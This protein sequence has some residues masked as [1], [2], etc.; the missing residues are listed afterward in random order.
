MRVFCCDKQ[1][2]MREFLI[3]NHEKEEEADSIISC[4]I[5]NHLG[6]L[7]ANGE[8]VVE[9]EFDG[10]N[11]MILY[12]DD[13][14]HQFSRSDNIQTDVFD[15]S[16]SILQSVGSIDMKFNI[17]ETEARLSG[18]VDTT[19]INRLEVRE[20]P[21]QML[22]TNSSQKNVKSSKGYPKS[23]VL[24]KKPRMSPPSNWLCLTLLPGAFQVHNLTTFLSGINVERCYM[25]NNASE[26][27]SFDVF[28]EFDKMT[29]CEAA[30]YRHQEKVFDPLFGSIVMEFSFVSTED[31][32]WIPRV[33]PR[34]S[35][36]SLE[37]CW[38][39]F[40]QHL[41][42]IDI[43]EFL[44]KFKSYVVPNL[45]TL[46][47]KTPCDVHYPLQEWSSS[48]FLGFSAD[49]IEVLRDEY[50][51]WESV[52]SR[53]A[54]SSMNKEGFYQAVSIIHRYLLHKYLAYLHESPSSQSAS[55]SSAEYEYLERLYRCSSACLQ[56]KFDA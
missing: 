24:P 3:Q 29:S 43:F 46:T 17:M 47:C 53:I 1:E 31:I 23:S 45:R 30:Y 41:H 19:P 7:L 6:A 25:R 37:K 16:D 21:P 14:P 11:S 55:S 32:L 56:G 13:I 10:N 4:R 48:Y 39:S 28:V 49:P 36:G 5:G 26:E 54:K 50:P 42:L 44:E 35:E 2:N 40:Y 33:M 22:T 34:F 51:S 12:I 15:V 8:H 9:V 38:K 20:T 27:N 18:R 52:Q